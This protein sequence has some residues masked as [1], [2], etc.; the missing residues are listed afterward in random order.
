MRKSR[1]RNSVFG[2]KIAD[3]IFLEKCL[4]VQLLQYFFITD[5]NPL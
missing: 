2:K 4:V 5:V 1:S 3:F